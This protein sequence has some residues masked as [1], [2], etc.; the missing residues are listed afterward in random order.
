M[1]LPYWAPLVTSVDLPLFG[2]TRI[3][4]FGPLVVLG[5]VL[6][7][8]A[9][10]RHGRERGLPDGVVDDAAWWALVFG[11]I[12]AHLVAVLAYHPQRVLE[13][14]WIVLAIWS[15]ISSTGG[16]IGALVGVF[17]WSRRHGRPLLPIADAL[18]FGLLVGFT[19]GRIGCALVHDHA[20][21]EASPDAWLALGPWPCALGDVSCTPT[22][23][24]DLGL[25]EALLCLALWLAF[26]RFYAWRRAPDGQLAGAVALAYGI[27]RMPLDLLRVDDARHFG[28]TFAQWACLGFIAIGAW[29]LVSTKRG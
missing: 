18:I 23:R 16:F 25:L 29:L 10:R 28:L 14:P 15:G 7:L 5:I 13:A 20:G 6:G 17:L 4:V 26:H 24:F 3:G 9:S 1:A 19:F 11:F 8:R 27:V 2:P 22:H 12:G 21:I